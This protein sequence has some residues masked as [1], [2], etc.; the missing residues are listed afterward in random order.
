MYVGLH[1]KYPLFVS[2]FNDMMYLLTAIGLSPGGRS[3]V[4][5]YTQ[6]IHRTIRN[7]Q[8]IEQHNNFETRIFSTGCRKNVRY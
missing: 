7:K 2:D 5:V 1:V 8:Y 6:T 4:H 3:T